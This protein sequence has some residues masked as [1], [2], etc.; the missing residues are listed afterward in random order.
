MRFFST[1]L[2]GAAL[3]SAAFGL[4]IDD[5][6]VSLEVGKSYEIKYSPATA[7]PTFILRKGL[8]GNLDTIGPI[9]GTASGGVFKFTVSTSLPNGNDYAFEIRAGNENNFGKNDVKITGSTATAVSSAA[10]SAS[11]SASSASKAS[12]ASSASAKST[13]STLTSSATLSISTSASGNST[14]ALPTLSR[15]TTSA[16]RSTGATVTTGGGAPQNTG[17]A[18]QLGS[19]PLALIFGA[20]AA[21]AYLN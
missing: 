9:S 19:S 18:S 10:S 2:A 4:T 16:P 5:Y 7:S 17:A 6:P 15:S 13:D 1:I 8:S 12:S 21:M 20:V 14:V 3:V 11:A